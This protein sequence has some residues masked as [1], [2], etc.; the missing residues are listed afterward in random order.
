[1]GLYHVAFKIG[2]T[3]DVLRE[4]KVHLEAHGVKILGMSDH[5]VSQ[6]LYVEDPDGIVVELFVDSDPAIWGRAPA[7]VATVRP[8]Q[9]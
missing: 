9:L 7:T 3:L 4:A 5:Q 8:L 6:S 2:D 1:M